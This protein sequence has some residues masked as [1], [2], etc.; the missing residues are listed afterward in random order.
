MA[1]YL[2]LW[3]DCD[4]ELTKVKQENYKLRDEISVL[5]REQTALL[6]YIAGDYKPE[7]REFIK[8]ECLRRYKEMKKG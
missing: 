1:D 6:A 5:K 4:I 7:W 8:A 2:K 3:T